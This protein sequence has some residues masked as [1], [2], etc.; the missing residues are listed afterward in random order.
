[1]KS[2]SKDARGFVEGVISHLKRGKSGNVAPKVQSLLLKMTATAKHEHQ[3]KVESAVKLTSAEIQA[4]ARVL[5]KVAGHEVSLT[6]EVNPA[7]IG[8]LRITM[9]DWVMDS[10]IRNELKEMA[11][12]V[13]VS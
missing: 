6:A 11:S 2:V 13:T 12:I 5:S 4:I 9:A 1:M 7:L 10:S 8:G 3:A